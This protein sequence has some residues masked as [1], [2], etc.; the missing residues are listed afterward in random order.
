MPGYKRKRS[1]TKKYAKKR[2]ITRR[3]RKGKTYNA[4]YGGL[5]G[6]EKKYIDY[7]P[8]NNAVAWELT[9]TGA[10]PYPNKILNVTDACLNSCAQGDGPSDRDGNK[11]TCKSLHIKGKICRFPEA[12]FSHDP[13]VRVLIVVDQQN[14]GNPNPTNDLAQITNDAILGFRDIEHISRYKVLWDKT[15]TIKQSV[16]Y[17]ATDLTVPCVFFKKN[18]KLGNMITSFKASTNSCANIT[19]NAI[20]LY[21]VTSTGNGDGTIQMD[22]KTRLRFYG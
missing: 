15:F 18:F 13:Q 9:A 8:A 10:N 2:R 5:L 16:A 22:F 21:A 4:R 1:T 3:S 7:T 19:D 11:I 20:K 14:N 17:N 12:S 6:L